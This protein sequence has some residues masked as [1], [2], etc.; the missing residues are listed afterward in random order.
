MTSDPT[1]LGTVQDVQG[2]TVKV[3][4]DERTVGG[5][6]FIDGHGYRIGQIGSFVRIPIGFNNLYGVISLVGVAEVPEAMADD[7]PHGN[8]W[9]TVQLVGEAHASGEF[10]R[11]VFE[12]PTIGDEVHLVTNEDLGIIYG[13]P[14]EL[15][16]VRVGDVVSTSALPAMVDIDHL[17]NRHSAVVGTTGSGKST[18]V[19][20]LL[21]AL[22]D[23]EQY[24]SSR[25]IIFDI[26]GEYQSA[27]RDRASV[28][29]VDD[30]EENRLFVP[31]WALT[32]EELLKMT[33]FSAVNDVERAVLAERVTELKLESLRCQP[34][35]G[36]TPENITVDTPVPFSFHR[37]WY[38]L[39]RDVLSTHTVAPSANQTSET[40]AIE[41]SED[42]TP[43]VGDIMDVVP[44]RYHSTTSGGEN[45]VYRSGSSLNIRRQII[46]TQSL[47]KDPRYDFI[48]RPGDW[49]P[50]PD[51]DRLDAQPCS[52]LDI[53]LENWIG[54]KHPISIFDLSGVPASILSEIIAVVVRILFD[55]LFW[56][57]ELSEGGRSRPLLCVFEEAH[58]YL[59]RDDGG[60]AIA[61]I[62]RV[63]KEGRKYGLGAMIVS[64]RPSEIDP[65]ILSQCGTLFALRLAN[66]VDRSHVTATYSDN[67]EGFFGLLPTL[68]TGEM[69]I[70]GESVR[71]PLRAIVDLPPPA[72][73]PNSNDPRVYDPDATKGW[74]RLRDVEDYSKLI[75]NW[76]GETSKIESAETTDG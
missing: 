45:R 5:L 54:S 66:S 24:P 33:P 25:I 2:S 13:R 38:E 18:T 44:P 11:G 46:A 72:K 70:V 16:F 47:L 62:R 56:G 48:F 74:N 69:I 6:V 9:V 35:L 26:H 55:S 50:R 17:I 22:S 49:C 67:F 53:L 21:N 31:Y 20:S 34:R 52:D 73:R 61:A 10:Q 12:Y 23:I 41:C 51:H 57:R 36:V 14:D 27:L 3:F 7:Q 64:Q 42:G 30:R 40:E 75:R 59:N 68:R 8:R 63:I 29:R 71:L 1:L 15:K 39:Y 19:A 65:T 32:F 43:F 28:F 4:L 37:L 60:P 76:R 58:A